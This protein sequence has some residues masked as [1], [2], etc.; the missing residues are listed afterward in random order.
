MEIPG[1]K[2]DAENETRIDKK[3]N[4]MVDLF[5]QIPSPLSSPEKEHSL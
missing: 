5:L 2:A 4:A 3:T 1:Q